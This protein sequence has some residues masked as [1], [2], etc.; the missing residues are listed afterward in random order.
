M[1]PSV[2]GGCGAWPEPGAACS[3]FLVEHD[4]FRLVVDLG[5]FEA[6]TRLLPHWL[7]NAGVRLTAG[8]QSLVYTGDAGPDRGLLDLARDAD[9]L[10]AEATY[11][12]TVPEHSRAHLSSAR[13]VGRQAAAAG[14]GRLVLTHL[15]PGTDP[16]AAR[17]AAA[18]SYAGEITVATP[19]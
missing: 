4:G 1:R 5:P 2:L 18:A 3:G 12:D 16:A 10:V 7:P 11:V 19:G 15:W 14:V 13:H 9:L 6:R 17:R 8:G